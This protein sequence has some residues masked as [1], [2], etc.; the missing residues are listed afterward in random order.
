VDRQPRAGHL[1]EFGL[2]AHQEIFDAVPIHLRS[3]FSHAPSS[4]NSCTVGI[5]AGDEDGST[6]L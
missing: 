5:D 3:L 2:D 4:S 6:S 1:Q